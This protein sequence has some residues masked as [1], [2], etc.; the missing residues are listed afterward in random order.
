MTALTLRPMTDAEYSAWQIAL[1]RDYA[2]EK[3]EAGQWPE[4]GSVERARRE[5]AELLPE[6]R[7]T[8]R[9]LLLTAVIPTGEAVGRVWIGLDHPRGVQGVAFLY[10]IEVH[11][12]RRGAGMGRALLEAAEGEAR[13]EGATA[14]EL[15]VFGSNE[16][17]RALYDSA[18]YAVMAQQ[19]RKPL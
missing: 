17:A 7:S 14:L 11:A 6:G 12:D 15:N 3:V 5:N 1:A 8:R 10:D 16:T 9:M 4:E 18:G 19:M 13:A 2:A